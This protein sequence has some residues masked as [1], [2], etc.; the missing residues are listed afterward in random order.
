MRRVQRER[1]ASGSRMARGVE[2]LE[3]RL[4]LSALNPTGQEQEML[5]LINRIRMNPATEIAQV[6]DSFSPIH[7]PD[8][9]VN[10]QLTA[11]NVS[12]AALQSQWATQTSQAPL[13]WNEAL[14]NAARDHSQAMINA[15]SQSHQTPGE[16]TLLSRVQTAGYANLQ[17]VGENIFAYADTVL[18]A[19]AGF[20]VDW[21]TP[22]VNGDGMQDDLGHRANVMSSTFREIG[23]GIIP[24]SNPSTVVGPLVVT[25]DFGTRYSFGDPW[26]LG[27]AWSDL[28]GDGRY[29]AGEG[30]GGVTVQ[31]IGAAGTFTT[32]TLSA[33]AYQWQLPAG[34]YTV[35]FSGPGV[36]AT[37]A[38]PVTVS[39]GNVKLD[40]AQSTFSTQYLFDSAYYVARY[41]EV[42]AA[43]ASGQV[44]SAWQHFSQIGQWYGYDPNPV[45]DT[46]HFLSQAPP[47]PPG[48][49]PFTYYVQTGMYASTYD[50]S[51]FFSRD[52]YRAHNPDVVAAGM[53]AYVHFTLYGHSELRNPSAYVDLDYYRD[54]N[55]DLAA[56]GVDLFEHFVTW[57]MAE[58]RTASPFFHRAYYQEMNPEVIAAG[59]LPYRHFV[60]Y[61]QFENRD[62]APLF[63]LSHYQERYSDVGSSGLAPYEHFVW[64]GQ[65]LDYNPSAYFDTAF[66]ASTYPEVSASGYSEFEHYLRW[67]RYEPR[68]PIAYFDSAYYA[69]Q[70]PEIASAVAAGTLPSLYEHYVRW[71]AA[72]GRSGSPYFLEGWYRT[73][74][75]DVAA[76]ITSGAFRSAYDHFVQYGATDPRKPNPWFDEAWYLTAYPT[77]A[78]A[79]AAGTY[80]TGFEHYIRLGRWLGNDPSTS[81]DESWYLA[82]DPGIAAAVSSGVFSCGF[83]HY[84]LYGRFEGRATAPPPNPWP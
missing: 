21:G 13:A 10:T 7:S 67:G 33:G 49:S 82:T 64:T 45:F 56:A 5:E 27:T 43:I 79:V 51:P 16:A 11:W 24:E 59:F 3:P 37:V 2:A 81:F 35:L 34:T 53:E 83:E 44:A 77:A 52:F 65:H 70:N 38:K 20:V 19:H 55:P 63:D 32:T 48:Q 71:G 41:P 25:Q 40:L 9:Y 80:R 60:L 58:G 12:G 54:Y 62:P 28:D 14:W 66:Y 73:A 84:M 17:T 76:V 50:P 31:A 36:T 29:D 4:L 15:N 47:V 23:I 1:V 46:A 39:A 61:G 26:L 72:E 57:G 6:V 68:N 30:L 75:P 69:Q 74:Y 22:D 78:S 42:A 18:E 8:P